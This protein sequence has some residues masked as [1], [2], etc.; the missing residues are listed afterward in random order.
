MAPINSLPSVKGLEFFDDLHRY[1]FDGVW[2]PYSVTHIC[3]FDMP[4]SRR[5]AIDQTR[6]QW[7][8]RGQAVHAAMEAF[9]TPD[10]DVTELPEYET[11]L[12][13]IEPLVHHP[14]WGMYKPLACE[15][16]MISRSRLFAGS[17]DCLLTDGKKIVLVDLKTQSSKR[18]APYDIRKQL[19]AYCTLL[20]DCHGLSV[21]Q[22]VALWARPGVC[23]QTLMDPSD[24][25]QVWSD[26]LEAFKA[27]LP[28]F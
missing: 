9:L 5:A 10:R 22:C 11:Y 3:S 20:E 8:P 28:D 24:C 7:A 18:S 13:W 17:L 16:R 25:I 19:G 27:Q 12:S 2:V 23:E 6:P 1:R 15:H 26:K 14:I 21:D 4:A